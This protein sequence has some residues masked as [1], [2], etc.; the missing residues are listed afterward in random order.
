MGFVSLYS[1]LPK[2]VCSA[3]VC[4]CTNAIYHDGSSQLLTVRNALTLPPTTASVSITRVPAEL[5]L[6][7]RVRSRAP[8]GR[9]QG[10]MRGAGLRTT[11]GGPDGPTG[12]CTDRSTIQ[13]RTSPV[14]LQHAWMAQYGGATL[15]HCCTEWSSRTPSS[16]SCLHSGQRGIH[17]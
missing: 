8:G 2:N 9:V 10:P 15:G 3:V 16:R 14:P 13:H 1:G 12:I 6:Q 5:R 11:L 7:L 4:V 17:L